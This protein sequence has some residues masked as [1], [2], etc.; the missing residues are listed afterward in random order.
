MLMGA[1]WGDVPEEAQEAIFGAVSREAARMDEQEV[2][3]TVYALGRMGV[4][5][6]EAPSEVCG[7]LLGAVEARCPLMAPA[8]VVMTL[9][10]LSRLK[11]RWERLPSSLRTALTEASARILRT[12]SDRTVSSLVHALAAVG[13]NWNQMGPILQVT[14]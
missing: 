10:G 7:E 4:R 13:A 8:G 14:N 11:L 3:N 12:A 2:G 9:L 1:S 5:W 6:L